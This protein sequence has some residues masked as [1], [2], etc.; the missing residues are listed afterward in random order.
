MIGQLEFALEGDREPAP[1]A[2]SGQG[3]SHADIESR[4]RAQV[5]EPGM[6]AAE[7]DAAVHDALDRLGLGP[8]AATRARPCLCESGP[9]LFLDALAIDR[10]CARCGREPQR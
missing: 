8:C 3:P 6:S 4:I 9:L 2:G 7:L 10:R 5:A 1:G